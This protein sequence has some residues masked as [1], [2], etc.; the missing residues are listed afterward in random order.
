MHEDHGVACRF[1]AAALFNPGTTPESIQAGLR[2]FYFDTALSAT[3]TSLPSL[4]A[5]A[6]PGHI[7]YGSDFP[8][9]HP[10]WSARFDHELASYDGPGAERLGE[11]HR[12]A[13]EELF[14]RLAK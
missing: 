13:A 8:Y 1:S 9:A 4:L 6:E 5:F 14:P 3:P 12:S 2:K 7:L 11:V 10:D